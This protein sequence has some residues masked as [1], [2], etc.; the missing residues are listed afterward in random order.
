MV[1]L[2]IKESSLLTAEGT[3]GGGRELL[4]Y[5][6]I[7]VSDAAVFKKAGG[8]YSCCAVVK[9]STAESLELYRAY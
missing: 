2:K 3:G 9:N 7:L 1:E 4:R 5:L 8:I 6:A